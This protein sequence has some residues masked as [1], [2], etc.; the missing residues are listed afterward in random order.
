MSIHNRPK[1]FTRIVLFIFSLAFSI[2]LINGCDLFSESNS[3]QKR[4]KGIPS[5]AFRVGGT[6]GGVYVV[7]DKKENS[8]PSIYYAEIYSEHFGDIL[9]KGQLMMQPSDQP[10]FDYK[11]QELLSAW[12]G[13]KL[14]LK[15]GRI[16][17]AIK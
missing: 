15:D 11:N 8:Q 13:E 16:L 17:K 12:D 5:T 10:L 6:D 1:A 2:I 14:Y 7:L 9:Y 4:P 3:E